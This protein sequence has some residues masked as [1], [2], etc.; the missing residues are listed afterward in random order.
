MADDLEDL[1][2]VKAIVLVRQ[3]AD[4][5][6][7]LSGPTVAAGQWLLGHGLSLLCITRRTWSGCGLLS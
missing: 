1:C 7:Q 2:D 3:L 6:L 4:H 5:D